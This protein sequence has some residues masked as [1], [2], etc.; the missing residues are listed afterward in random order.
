MEGTESFGGVPKARR[1]EKVF[2][3][4]FFKK[5]RPSKRAAH[6][7]KQVP[8]HTSSQ[9][10]EQGTGRQ[11]TREIPRPALRLPFPHAC[12]KGRRTLSRAGQAGLRRSSWHLRCHQGS[13][14]PAR[15][16]LN[17]A[18]RAPA[19]PDEGSCVPVARAQDRP[20]RK[21]RPLRKAFRRKP[22]LPSCVCRRR[23]RPQ[24]RRPR[25][26]TTFEKVDE[27]FTFLHPTCVEGPALAERKK[28]ACPARPRA[29]T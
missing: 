27:T 1:R 20:E 16:A 13:R 9:S 11:R 15:S 21:R 17:G 29:A 28:A 19:P 12:A 23:L 26:P 7:K 18:H 4:T 10:C 3:E 24:G 14:L 5:F 25:T 6:G 8:C 22:F 2:D